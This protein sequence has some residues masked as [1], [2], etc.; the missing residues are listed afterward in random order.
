[1][2][3]GVE[4]AGIETALRLGRG[5]IVAAGGEPP[6][7]W[8]GA[9]RFT[10]DDGVLAAPSEMVD[11]LHEHWSHRVPF[12]IKLRCDANELRAPETNR[13]PPYSLSP[14]FDLSRDRLYFLARA[15]NYD[16]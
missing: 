7:A 9:P 14:K 4:E 10:I 2:M 6:G 15:N 5:V 16:N 8:A 3:R 12:V 13:A 1:M 11:V